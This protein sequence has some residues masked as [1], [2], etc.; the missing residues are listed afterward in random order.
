[1]DLAALM[2]G[3]GPIRD[4]MQKQEGEREKAVLEG[5][6]GGGAVRVLIG[7][8]L[9][10]KKVAIAPAAAA[11]VA[12]DPA[13]LED[14]VAAAVGNALKA[15]RDRFGVGAEEQMQKLMGGDLGS[16][17]SAFGRG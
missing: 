15:W 8:D 10:V 13:L 7:G 4:R 16:L 17:L 2:A 5:S 3:M 11:A 6:A 1:M 14:L 9:A 12:G